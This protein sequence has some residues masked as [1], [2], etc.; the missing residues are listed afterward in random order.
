[1]PGM[2]TILERHRMINFRGWGVSTLPLL[3]LL[4]SGCGQ[5]VCNLEGVMCTDEY[6]AGE[7]TCTY[8][9]VSVTHSGCECGAK[10]ALYEALCDAGSDATLDEVDEGMVCSPADTGG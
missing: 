6:C 7:V 3:L 2:A 8:D 9:G 5:T 1:M 10:V 4:A